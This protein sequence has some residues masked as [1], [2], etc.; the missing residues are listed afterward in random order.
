MSYTINIMAKISLIIAPLVLAGLAGVLAGESFSKEQ[1]FY[2][3]PNYECPQA[4]SKVAKEFFDGASVYGLPSKDNL[5]LAENYILS[6]DRKLKHPIWVLEHLKEGQMKLRAAK[7]NESFFAE[8]LSLH[9][10][11]QST[12]EDY[13]ATGYDRGHMAPASDNKAS[14]KLMDQSFCLS[15]IAPQLPGL[16]RGAW[17]RLETYVTHL[18][19]RSKNLYVVSGALFLP[20]ET[21]DGPEVVY[22]V[23]GPN[24]VAVPTHFYK[25][26]LTED[27]GGNLAMEAFLMANSPETTEEQK[28][29]TFRINV[30]RDLPKIERASGLIFFD[31]VDR[32][33][34]ERP[35]TFKYKYNDRKIVFF[36]KSKKTE[37]GGESS[38]EESSDG[39]SSE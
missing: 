16:N 20:I 1:Y 12:N 17:V 3:P 9:E 33:R 24:H 34:I 13:F 35:E 2:R 8:D 4:D 37:S 23:L 36:K 19:R 38:P 22:K 32:T 10:Y 6:Y 5:K 28:L 25:V 30:I 18:A 29:S 7:R 21:P 26:L 31:K 11:F 15:N 14:Q 39:S 27:K